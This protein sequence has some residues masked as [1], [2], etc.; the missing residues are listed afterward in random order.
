MSRD[1][2]TPDCAIKDCRRAATRSG[3]CRKHHAMV[4]GDL[5]R[6]HMM[7]QFAATMKCASKW[8]GRYIAAVRKQL[9]A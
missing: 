6:G 5:K 7:D 4:P 1:P 8:R 2:H 3:L 9:A